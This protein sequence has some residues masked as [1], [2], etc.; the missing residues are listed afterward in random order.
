MA[1]F[2]SSSARGVRADGVL[3]HRPPG[4][5][6]T[7]PSGRCPWQQPRR[8]LFCRDAADAT[9]PAERKRRC[10]SGRR[11][12]GPDVLQRCVRTCGPAALVRPVRSSKMRLESLP[13][14]TELAITA[15]SACIDWWCCA[16]KYTGEISSVSES[17]CERAKLVK[18]E[19]LF[20]KWA[21]KRD[22]RRVLFCFFIEDF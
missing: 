14:S 9:W 8:A 10:R 17:A 20:F 21:Y 12:V 11:A 5:P 13:I 22:V 19:S 18:R 1:L 15:T 6:P 3:R 16:T 2:P 4:V 7:P